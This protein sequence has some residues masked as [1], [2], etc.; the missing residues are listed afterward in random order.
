MI[1]VGITELH[2]IAKEIALFPPDNVKYVSIHPKKHFIDRIV[3]STAKGVFNYFEDGSVDFIEA[4]LFPVVTSNK[5]I[6]TPADFPTVMNFG[7]MGFS[8]PRSLRCKILNHLF[9]KAQF[10][11]LLFK[12]YAG[13]RTFEQYGKY[14]ED[15]VLNKTDVL[16][17]PIRKVDDDLIRF[18]K[19]Y[20]NI[21]FVGDF[22]RKGGAHV[23]DAFE[24]L[25]NRF[26]NIK[27]QICVKR[28][29][30]DNAQLVK[31]YTEKINSNANITWSFVEREKMMAEIMPETDIFVCPTY[32]DS[33][34]YAIEEAMAYG[35]P[36]IATNQCAI[37]EI[38]EHNTNGFLIDIDHFDFVKN[39]KDYKIDFIPQNFK[40][41]MNN[42][43]IKYMSEL[44]SNYELRLSF[45]MK[46]L[47]IART[48][49]SFERRNSYIA[50]IYEQAAKQTLHT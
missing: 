43:V 13:M 33:Y 25:Q 1:R 41:Y 21:L 5:W 11:K 47:H 30:S 8:I 44:I 29:K 48:K 26:N 22:F 32:K 27:L 42:M 6:Y 10:I 45:G 36:V 20:I 50:S 16:Y 39:I 31:E 28:L 2:G 23:V 38:V 40:E 19:D 37:P 17:P 35:I 9:N 3:T 14:F 12:S 24:Q 18:N 49:F 7:F 15:S 4:P 46:S 34:G